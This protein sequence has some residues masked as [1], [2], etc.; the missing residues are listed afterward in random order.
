VLALAAVEE[1]AGQQVSGYGRVG[2]PLDK[3]PGTPVLRR[4]VPRGLV[5][6]NVVMQV[7]D[8]EVR[9]A[10]PPDQLG[11]RDHH[12]LDLRWQAHGFQPFIQG[13]T[14][15]SMVRPL[16]TGTPVQSWQAPQ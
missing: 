1:L 6:G 16:V 15:L 14:R 7:A 2:L 12:V 5:D 10:G 8:L 3:D 13:R 11:R 4:G 9:R